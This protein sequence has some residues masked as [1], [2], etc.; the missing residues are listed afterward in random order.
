MLDF[1]SDNKLNAEEVAFADDLTVAGKLSTI[2]DYWNQL[3][4][5]G[6]KYGY[7]PKASKSY[8]MVKEDQLPNATTLFDNSNVNI[9]VKGKRHLGAIVGSVI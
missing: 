1:I 3:R 5:I 2:K 9:T 4:S 7:F 6:P 8:L